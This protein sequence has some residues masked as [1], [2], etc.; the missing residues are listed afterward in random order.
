MKN[1]F[2]SWPI[3]SKLLFLVA[4]SLVPS[5]ILI[6]YN[7]RQELN[8]SIDDAGKGALRIA[9]NIAAQQEAEV[10]G[11]RKMFITLARLSEFQK[12]D[13]KGCNRIL[14]EIIKNDPHKLNIGA[15]TP[16]GLIFASGEYA[17]PFKISVA[18]RKY[19]RDAVRTRTFSVGE[20]TLGKVTK[21]PGI[22]FSYPILSMAGKLHGVIFTSLDFVWLN[23]QME[24][25]N[26]PAGSVI[27]ISDHKGT[28]L[29]RNVDPDKSI[30]YADVDHI[31]RHMTEG[32]DAGTF[33]E[34]GRDGTER[35]YAFKR[36][37]L[38]NDSPPYLYMRIGIPLEAAISDA[39]KELTKSLLLLGLAALLSLGIAWYL[40]EIV[41]VRRIK[42]VVEA[43]RAFGEGN[44]KR[45][46]GVNYEG[47]IG[48]LARTFDEIAVSLEE[49][50]A[51]QRE[52][53]A[54]FRKLFES[55]HVGIILVD[56]ETRKIVDVNRQALNM[57]NYGREDVLNQVCHNFMCPAQ[58]ND[59]PILDGGQIVDNT[60]R[61]LIGKGGKWVP[62]LKTAVPLEVGGH[63]YL[64]E[65]FVD[66]SERKRSEEALQESEKQYR[67]IFESF[68]DLYFQTDLYGRIQ[69]VSPSVTRLAGYDPDELIGQSV[70]LVYADEEERKKLV[71]A[72]TVT[73]R[74]SN[75]EAVMY[76][77]TGEEIVAS[78]NARLMYDKKDKPVGVEGVIRD[79]TEIKHAEEQ[80]KAFNR[81]LE[82]AIERANHMAL[83]ASVASQAKSSFLAN[84]SHEIR[85]PMNGV[86]GMAGLLLD[87]DLPPQQR[88]YIEIIR[89]SG[90]ALLSL[91]N[92]ILDFSKIEARKLELEIIDFNLRSTIREVVELLS[93]NA[94]SKGID[95][96]SIVETD[97]PSALK[98]DPGRLRQILINLVGNAV[99]FTHE[100]RISI[101]VSLDHE[102][103]QRVFIRFEVKDTGIG[104]PEEKL[105][106]L[107]AP[108]V[109][110]DGS[111]TRKYGGTGLGLAISKQLAEI[112]DGRIGVDSSPGKG[113]I[114]WFTASFDRQAE[115]ECAAT[116]AEPE[117]EITMTHDQRRRVRIL[118]VEDNATNQRVAV[119]MLTK[120]G[121][122]AD[123]AA[124]GQEA[125]KALTDFP[126]DL[127]LMD[128]QMPEMDGFEATRMIRD[129][130]T[131]VQDHAVPVIAMTAHATPEDRE[132]CLAAGMDDYITKPV[133]LN[134][135]S[136]TLAKW[137]AGKYGKAFSSDSADNCID[138]NLEADDAGAMA[139][140]I[141]V[142]FDR[143]GFLKRLGDDEELAKTIIKCFLSDMP[144]QLETLKSAIDSSDCRMAGMQSH[145]I[146]GAAANVGGTV[147]REIAFRMEKA[148]KADEMEVLRKSWPEL[149][150]AFNSLQQVLAGD[151]A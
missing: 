46:T 144:V 49:M 87:M 112:M 39:G 43:V 32:R 60:E 53:E 62:V 16:E 138:I 134:M 83:Q 35:L 104:I 111:T 102:A 70:A 126:Y 42:K 34:K 99:K 71:K 74:V 37:T 105:E 8:K 57:M 67:S 128:C 148:A 97:V 129:V 7:T 82:L 142:S 1:P 103:E 30:G 55:V 56:A 130:K 22:H 10:N 72:L 132:Q 122:R 51:G 146:K 107:F 33:K 95:L 98:G 2:L 131:S 73:G 65:S 9:E 137:L 41:F 20:Y 50:I 133:T 19:F 108:F 115:I 28:I 75:F 92:D 143:E 52:S 93:I 68:E 45:R 66:I 64:L 31:R 121:Y 18:E 79:V 117:A 150:K 90:E 13:I 25:M 84:M 69:I 106:M 140:D 59:C 151:L 101:R 109:Q 14:R 29:F 78:L 54:R 24:H 100:G 118:L 27:N 21:R 44:L 94:Q 4:V 81:E 114:F 80:L 149:D 141:R 63:S 113:S 17:E 3:R 38:G 123:I 89:S 5:I 85:T 91:I 124:N 120:L 26:L 40:G 116:P 58:M 36:L 147:M 88:Q 135:L 96:E 23:R 61:V 77:K 15:T 47:E 48:V 119:A 110:I 86:I 11:I 136:L 127:V 145:K 125:I 6:I 139:E 12:R 76:K